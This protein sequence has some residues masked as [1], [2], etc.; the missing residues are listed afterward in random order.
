MLKKAVLATTVCILLLSN[1]AAAERHLLFIHQESE[2]SFEHI[3]KDHYYIDIHAHSETNV[4]ADV[5]QEIAFIYANGLMAETKNHVQKKSNQ[6]E[7]TW[8]IE[9]RD[10][11]R[12]DIITLH[13]AQIEDEENH[14]I[15]QYT[16]SQDRIYVLCSALS[17]NR[18]FRQPQSNTD[19]Q[20]QRI[21]DHTIEKKWKKHWNHLID[22]FDIAL[23]NYESI[24][25]NH[26]P[27][28]ANGPFAT[29]SEDESKQIIRQIWDHLYQHYMDEPLQNNGHPYKPKG[30][31]LPLILLANDGSH[32]R[33]LYQTENDQPIQIN[34]PLQFHSFGQKSA[35]IAA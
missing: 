8:R 29:F 2:F 16:S 6:A 14:I 7:K 35:H 9:G 15:N 25:L 19:K 12:Y 5:Q 32:F 23:E 31:I 11:S 4:T 33:I 22:T 27:K 26:F 17:E 1:T 28:Y 13:Y 34:E 3:E 21:I 10:S 30:S 18:A 20:W 24:P